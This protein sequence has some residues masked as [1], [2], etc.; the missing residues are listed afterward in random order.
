MTWLVYANPRAGMGDPR[1]DPKLCF[2]NGKWGETYYANKLGLPADAK[3]VK[4]KGVAAADMLL[5]F[6]VDAV[7][8]CS[9]RP[10]EIAA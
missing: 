10:Q 8:V 3:A 1:T 6:A 7:V 5:P 2:R 4:Q 9:T